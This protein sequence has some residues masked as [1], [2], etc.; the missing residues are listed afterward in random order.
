MWHEVINPCTGQSRIRA[1][2]LIELLVVIAIIA[3]LAAMLL[4]ALATAKDKARMA[5]C[6]SNLRQ[7][8]LTHS[9]Y[10]GDNHNT[11][12]ETC[13]IGGYNRAPGVIFLNQ[14]PFPQYFNM[15]AVC[16][17][18]PGMHLDL[19]DAAKII[20]GGIWW[21]PSSPKA[22]PA[23]IRAT[24]AAGW[25]DIAYSYFAR[26]ENWKP[27]QAT[28]PSDLTERELRTDR[29]LMADKLHKS[30]VYGSWSYNHGKM[31]GSFF[32]DPG[33]PKISG[34][35]HLYGDGRVIWK[36]AV[37][38]K[39]QDLWMGNPNVGEVPGPGS[40]TFY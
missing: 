14:Q 23:N 10:G 39:M 4:T 30:T 31:P 36:P 17:Y 5:Q 21:C 18:L 38:F 27:G 34:I 33:P 26:V 29:L 1:V 11:L 16:P 7:W 22:D 3:I 2:T 8:G 37:R 19:A 20:V 35:H 40:T 25:F 9:L 6:K 12:L 15:E 13:E 28:M 32:V 24:A